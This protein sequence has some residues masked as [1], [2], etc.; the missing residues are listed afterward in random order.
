M[1]DLA[2]RWDRCTA[3]FPTREQ[4]LLHITEEH[5]KP[6]KPM[7][8]DE[9]IMMKKLDKAK[10]ESDTTADTDHS[11]SSAATVRTSLHSFF[12]SLHI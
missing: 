4:L 8:K 7:P 6:M 5:V 3:G 11:W 9:I 12:S 10:F 1:S 2:C